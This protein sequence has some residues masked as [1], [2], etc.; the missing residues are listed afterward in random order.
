MRAGDQSTKGEWLHQSLLQKLPGNHDYSRFKDA[1]ASPDKHIVASLL[2]LDV[3][4]IDQGSFW[5]LEDSIDELKLR[6]NLAAYP[7]MMEEF[8]SRRQASN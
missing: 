1:N 4:G 7:A 6:A 5:D 8:E 3:Y 2:A